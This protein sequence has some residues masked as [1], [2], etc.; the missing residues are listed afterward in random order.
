MEKILL[1]NVDKP[2]SHKLDTYL[3]GGGYRALKKALGT[4]QETLI[5]IVKDSGIRG[6]GGAGFPAGLKWSFIPKD[7]SIELRHRRGEGLYIHKGRV[8]VRR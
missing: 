8:R 6:R 7:P 5:Q 4:E 1:K 3:A 2:D